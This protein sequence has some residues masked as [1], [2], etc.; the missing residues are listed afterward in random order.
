MAAA[1]SSFADSSFA[2]SSFADSSFA[3]SSLIEG[4]LAAAREIEAEAA[5]AAKAE[6]DARAEA[7]PLLL[8]KSAAASANSAMANSAMAAGGGG[9]DS[10]WL[11][12]HD[13]SA[14]W[15]LVQE[16][17]AMHPEKAHIDAQPL[18]PGAYDLPASV[19][20]LAAHDET[21]ACKAQATRFSAAATNAALLDACMPPLRLA[22]AIAAEVG[23]VRVPTP[24]ER[25]TKQAA[26]IG[27]SHPN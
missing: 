12:L 14:L 27:M 13:A 24:L 1:D 15:Q 11:E 16:Y 19:M 5:A 2:D 22:H 10:R 3:D 25:W 6:A 21:E 23:S 26:L 8:S 17:K 9:G 20:L 18:P 4:G 7:A